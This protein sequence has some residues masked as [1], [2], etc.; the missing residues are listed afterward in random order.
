MNISNMCE[1]DILRLE[2]E[3]TNLQ[4][5]TTGFNHIISNYQYN[6]DKSKILYET[7]LSKY[8]TIKENI[9]SLEN[10]LNSEKYSLKTLE[11]VVKINYNIYVQNE[12]NLIKYVSKLEAYER[13]LHTITIDI[14]IKEMTKAISQLEKERQKYN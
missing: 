8:N 7:C 5:L 11:K 1:K 9:D 10:Q 14:K 3:K 4:S 2:S 12:E 6:R 13:K